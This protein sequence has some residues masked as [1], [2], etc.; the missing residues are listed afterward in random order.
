MIAQMKLLHFFKLV[1]PLLIIALVPTPLS[2]GDKEYTEIEIDGEMVDKWME[3]ASINEYDSTGNRVRTI[4]YGD[5]SYYEFRYEYNA[6]GQLIHDIYSKGHQRNGESYKSETWHTYNKKGHN[7]YSKS[8]DGKEYWYEY[9]RNGNEIHTEDSDGNETWSEYNSKG[10]LL[11]YK[12]SHGYEYWY[13]WDDNGKLIYSKGSDGK[14]E[15][16]EYDTHGNL[17]RN[18]TKKKGKPDEVLV[19]ILEYH[20]DSKI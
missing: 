4:T 15:W 19:Y 11:H 20:K 14:E 18:N 13:Q 6:K 12:S 5:Y 8:S 3:L 17:V 16:R 9:D 2:A 1:L 10:R 7:I